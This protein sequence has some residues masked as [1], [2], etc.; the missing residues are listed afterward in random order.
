MSWK[1]LVSAGLL[2]VLASPA[3]AVPTLHVESGGLNA[4][5]D[6]IWN[7]SITPTGTTSPV[8]A[9]LEAIV[10]V[11]HHPSAIGVH[12]EPEKIDPRTF[13]RG[14]T[15]VANAFRACWAQFVIDVGGTKVIVRKG[16]HNALG[17]FGPVYYGVG[18]F[19]RPDYFKPLSAEQVEVMRRLWTQDLVTFNGKFHDLRDVN[20]NPAPVQR[21]IPVWFGG[22]SDAVVKRAA[23][24]GDGWMP[25]M[26]PEEAAPKI[27][28]RVASGRDRWRAATVPAAAVR[29]SVR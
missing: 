20:I 17:W 12:L 4:S 1:S 26:K 28:A 22:S 2:C 29:R 16:H 13:G 14:G 21:P 15:G 18:P 11:L 8:A 7:V 9:E 10:T 5:G 25:I 6:W 24:I 27:A 23:R 19:G 3:F